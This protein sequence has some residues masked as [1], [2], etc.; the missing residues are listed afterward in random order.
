MVLNNLIEAIF[1]CTPK[2]LI[3]PIRK[4]NRRISRPM[5]GARDATDGEEID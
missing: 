2:P 4:S 5:E 1:I 3:H